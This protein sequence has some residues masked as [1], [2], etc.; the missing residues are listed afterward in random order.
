ME[1]KPIMRKTVLLLELKPGKMENVFPPTHPKK[2]LNQLEK[3]NR[4]TQKQFVTVE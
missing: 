1:P 3:M 4:N 2:Q